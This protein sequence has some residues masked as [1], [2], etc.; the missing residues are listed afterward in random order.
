[1]KFGNNVILM[2]VIAIAIYAVFLFIRK[3]EQ[4]PEGDPAGYADMWHEEANW[5]YATGNVGV[6]CD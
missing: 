2:V 6:V 3:T 1:M 4:T 5:S